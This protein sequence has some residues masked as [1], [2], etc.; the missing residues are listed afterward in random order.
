MI[1][2]SMLIKITFS[3][4]ES[5]KLITRFVRFNPVAAERGVYIQ[6]GYRVGA[7]YIYTRVYIYI[8]SVSH[9]TVRLSKTTGQLRWISRTLVRFKGRRFAI[10]ITF[11]GFYSCRNTT[12]YYKYRLANDVMDKKERVQTC[13][14]RRQTKRKRILYLRRSDAVRCF[15]VSRGVAH[16]I[17][18]YKHNIIRRDEQRVNAC[19][20]IR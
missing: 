14:R 6:P 17:I 3:E 20:R 8:N 7:V 19:N 18:S 15:S 10:I 12:I 2:W 11:F 5:R 16:I 4:V 1:T 9:A 13:H